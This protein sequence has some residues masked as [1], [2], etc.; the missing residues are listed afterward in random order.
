MAPKRPEVDV[1]RENGLQMDCEVDLI[2]G[3]DPGDCTR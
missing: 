2:R 1:K 3:S